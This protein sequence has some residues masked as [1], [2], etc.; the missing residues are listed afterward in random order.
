MQKIL[1]TQKSQSLY[2]N[3][4]TMLLFN[5]FPL[6]FFLFFNQSKVLNRWMDWDVHP[7]TALERPCELDILSLFKVFDYLPISQSK[8]YRSTK[9]I[10]FSNHTPQLFPLLNSVISSVWGHPHHPG[11]D[12]DQDLLHKAPLV[13]QTVKSICLQWG[14]PRFYPQVGR[15]S[16]RKKWQP[17]PVF[18]PGKSHGCRSLV[19]YSPWGCKESD[20]TERLH[21]HF[22]LG[23]SRSVLSVHWSWA[24]LF[25]HTSSFPSSPTSSAPCFSEALPT[26]LL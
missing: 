14:R 5:N 16:W 4:G 17:T 15:I 20:T 13:A 10:I 1:G 23:T 8:I 21:F 2:R 19:G 22:L 18:L 25:I 3:S 24:V 6:Y 26:T 12:I 9:P 11:Q 7:H